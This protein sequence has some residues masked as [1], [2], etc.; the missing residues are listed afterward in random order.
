MTSLQPSRGHPPV[1]L[2]AK[3]KVEPKVEIILKPLAKLVAE[4]IET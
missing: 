2:R 3:L 1:K 4:F